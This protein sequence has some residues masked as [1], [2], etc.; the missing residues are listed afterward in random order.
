MGIMYNNLFSQFCVK[1]LEKIYIPHE[2]VFAYK[3]QLKE[4]RMMLVRNHTQEY[5]CTMFALMGLYFAQKQAISVF[6]DIES[7]Y[8]VM[9]ARIEEVAN[10]PGEIALTVW[11]GNCI[12]TKIPPKVTSLFHNLL[13][14]RNPVI[15]FK[16]K[17]LTWSIAACLT[18]GE[19]Y[20]RNALTLAKLAADKYIN[21]ETGLARQFTTGLRK[22]WSSFGEHSYLAYAFL[23]LAQKT[24]NAW[25]RDVGLSIARKLVQLQGPQGQWGWMYHV[26]SGKLTEYY[27]I[28][29]VHQYAYA[30]FFLAK[31]IDL[32]YNEF[33]YPL[34]NGFRW[35]LGQ[36]EIGQYMV[37]PMH[38]IIWK[39]VMKKGINTKLI[40]ALKGHAIIYSGLRPAIKSAKDLQIDHHCLGWEMALPLCIFSGRKD[41]GEILNNSCFS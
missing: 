27:P 16:P 4:G 10:S 34:I 39:S 33:R 31:A 11:A 13:K 41:F 29:S 20:Y 24:G 30:P 37:E 17:S 40:K 28:Y 25:A 2:H 1:G 3:R 8:H 12:N 15:P 14:C 9:S 36:N 23:L 22:N 19:K 32:G 21:P 35:I 5:R 38:H 26:P 6:L 7:E 18:G